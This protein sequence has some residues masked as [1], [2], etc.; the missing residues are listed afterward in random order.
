MQT[1]DAPSNHGRIVAQL[2]RAVRQAPPLA[3]GLASSGSNPWQGRRHSETLHP[4]TSFE[5]PGGSTLET[6]NRYNVPGG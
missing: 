2:R 5:P 1:P 4:I 6:F 3:G